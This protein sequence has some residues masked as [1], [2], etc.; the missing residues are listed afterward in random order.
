MH[1]KIIRKIYFAEK[2]QQFFLKMTKKL[3]LVYSCK[4]HSVLCT[5]VNDNL[6]VFSLTVFLGDTS[7]NK[8]AVWGTT[9]S[10]RP[11]SHA[12][13]NRKPLMSFERNDQQR[14]ARST[15]S[16][17]EEGGSLE[18]ADQPK[19]NSIENHPSQLDATSAKSFTSN[20]S[21]YPTY[22]HTNRYNKDSY[23]YNRHYPPHNRSSRHQSNSTSS[24]QNTNHHYSSS[25]YAKSGGSSNSA[26]S[27]TT[28]SSNYQYNNQYDSG[29][30]RSSS[31]NYYSYR[32]GQGG[33]GYNKENSGTVTSGKV[34]INDGE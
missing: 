18:D 19:T 8:T 12:T 25:S 17:H 14:H 9:A 21:G 29:G 27:S 7:N 22:H 1:Q 23:H 6:P 33:Y 13:A 5:H 15:E 11:P 10:H 28:S 2:F 30:W 16:K 20:G 3:N 4:Q 26:N 32:S 31:R 34:T 24:C